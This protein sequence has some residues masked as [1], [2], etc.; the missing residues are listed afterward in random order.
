MKY[1]VGI[2]EVHRTFVEVELPDGATRDQIIEAAQKRFEEN[3]S[4][5]AYLEYSHTLEHDE[6][7]VCTEKG[8]F[9]I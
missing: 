9:V 7:T 1:A 5:D 3:G 4:D 8:D 6:W 2:P